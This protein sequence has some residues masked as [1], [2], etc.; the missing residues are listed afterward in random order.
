M[1][2]P[3]NPTYDSINAANPATLVN[4][5][6]VFQFLYF[7]MVTAK[8]WNPSSYRISQFRLKQY[9]EMHGT[10]FHIDSLLICPRWLS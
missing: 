4:K 10:H 9:R 5:S 7:I 8:L 3:M 6:A 1:F 2:Q